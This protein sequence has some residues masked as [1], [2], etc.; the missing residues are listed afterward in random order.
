MSTT[1]ERTE[2]AQVV[3]KAM[4]SR[5][6]SIA[7]SLLHENVVFDFPGNGIMEGPKRVSLFIR[8][9]LRKFPELTFTIKNVI[10]DGDQACTVWTNKGKNLDGS[11]YENSGITLFHFSEGKITF[12]SDYFKNTSFVNQS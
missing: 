4:N 3:F 7:E 9:L 1:S 6:L 8:V 11:L 10:L 2:L 12:M 5:D